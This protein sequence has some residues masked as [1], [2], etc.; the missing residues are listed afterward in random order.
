MTTNQSVRSEGKN[1]MLSHGKETHSY[2]ERYD[3]LSCI[4]VEI[5]YLEAIKLAGGHKKFL[6]KIKKL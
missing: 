3:C 1:L 5:D 6:E 4:Q 2:K